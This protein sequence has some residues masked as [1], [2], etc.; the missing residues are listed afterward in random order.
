[1]LFATSSLVFTFVAV[2]GDPLAP[3]RITPN[4][5]WQTIQNLTENKHLDDPGTSDG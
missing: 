2:S 4:V 5:S 3:L 1:M